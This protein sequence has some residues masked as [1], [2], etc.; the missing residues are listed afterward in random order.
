MSGTIAQLG[1]EVNSGDAVQAATDLDKLTQAGAKAEA[2]AG[3][4][5]DGFNKAGAS[6]AALAQAESKLA[7]SA[8]DAKTRLLN[9]AKAS[10]E[11]SQYNQSLL[12]VLM[13]RLL[14]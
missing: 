9:M 13:V 11:A 3:G 10:L 6:A 7:E 1:I 5:T 2:A 4:V 8:E 12:L 14:R